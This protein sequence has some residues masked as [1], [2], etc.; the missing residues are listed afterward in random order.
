MKLSFSICWH[1]IHQIIFSFQYVAPDVYLKDL[2]LHLKIY[3]LYTAPFWF[4]LAQ[5]KDLSIAEIRHKN[6][7][8]CLFFG[9]MSTIS[10]N[11]ID[12]D[13]RSCRRWW[14]RAF[15]NPKSCDERGQLH[16]YQAPKTF[17]PPSLSSSL[18]TSSNNDNN[19]NYNNDSK[20]KTRSSQ[21]TTNEA[22]SPVGSASNIVS[23]PGSIYFWFTFCFASI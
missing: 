4:F 16:I 7:S 15:R 17:P 1:K 23:V 10:C 2:V 13:G 8:R 9:I 22:N 11:H 20:M 5:Q 19:N 21:E 14:N 6:P 3:L 18:A 12:G